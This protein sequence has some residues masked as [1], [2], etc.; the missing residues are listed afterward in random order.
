[1]NKQILKVIENALQSEKALFPLNQSWQYLHQQYNIGRT[2]GN[3]LELTRQDKAELQ[4]LVEK[5]T[6][7]DFEQTTVTNFAVMHREQALAFAMDEKLAGQAVKRER[8]AIKALTSL[9][10]K[11]NDQVYSLPDCGHLDMA[12]ADIARTG[13]NAIIVIENYRCFDRLGKLSLYLPEHYA[14]PLVLYR[15]DNSYSENTVRQLLIKLD[16]P[17]LVMAD[18]DPKGLVIAQSTVNVVGLIAPYLADLE[19]FLSD[20]RKANPGLYAKQLAAC[21]AALAGS[22]HDLIRKMWG[23]LKRHQAGIVQEHW[24][25]MDCK[26]I[27]HSLNADRR[28]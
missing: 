1:L 16:L 12:L 23:M 14:D 18:I 28:C 3:R 5:V 13:H 7:I 26:L 19:A 20:R 2:Q 17:V 11:I 15:G 9:A 25:E 8:L 10:L 27:L 6:G 22:P 24:L 21:Q 4:V